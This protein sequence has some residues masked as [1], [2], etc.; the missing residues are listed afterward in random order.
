NNHVA[1]LEQ[2]HVNSKQIGKTFTDRCL[3][4]F[5]FGAAGIRLLGWR[6]SSSRFNVWKVAQPCRKRGEKES[7][8]TDTGLHCCRAEDLFENLRDVP[9]QERRRRRPSR[10]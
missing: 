7:N 5:C 1:A 10:D 4:G 2:H 3:D 9:W 6:C 8:R